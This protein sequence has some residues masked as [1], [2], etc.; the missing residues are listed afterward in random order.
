MDADSLG[1]RLDAVLFLSV[2]N[3]AVLVGIGF[4]YAF[5][6]TFA[7]VVFAGLIG[8]GLFRR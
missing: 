7:V 2:V 3:L 4:K 8:Y 1:W 6:E 5:D